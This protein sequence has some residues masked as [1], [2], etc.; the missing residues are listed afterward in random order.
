MCRIYVFICQVLPLI[1]P[2]LPVKTTL[3][4]NLTLCRTFQTSCYAN[5]N[6]TEVYL[7]GTLAHHRSNHRPIHF[8]CYCAMYSLCILTVFHKSFFP[9][10]C[11]APPLSEKE[12]EVCMF[13]SNPV[14]IQHVDTQLYFVLLLYLSYIFMSISQCGFGFFFGYHRSWY[15]MHI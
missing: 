2:A 7:A 8:H 5:S 9:F 1:C 11:S 13:L 6:C 10:Y 4:R 15:H 14:K 12:V 3:K